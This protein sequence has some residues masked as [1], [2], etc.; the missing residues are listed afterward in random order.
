MC[1]S[2][3]IFRN[4]DNHHVLLL[5]SNHRYSVSTNLQY[6]LRFLVQTVQMRTYWY[7]VQIMFSAPTSDVSTAL[8]IRL[9][10]ICA[11]QPTLIKDLFNNNVFNLAKTLL[12]ASL[13]QIPPNLVLQ[14]STMNKMHF[15]SNFLFSRVSFTYKEVFLRSHQTCLLIQLISTASH[16]SSDQN[17]K[18]LLDTF[19]L[20]HDCF[21]VQ[22]LH[23]R[24]C[25]FLQL[26]VMQL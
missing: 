15:S 2:F 1:I 9:N 20:T 6:S 5:E 18:L 23:S 16:C 22:R 4:R 14:L 19:S 25:Y 10:K 3:P 12:L 24:Q 8:R 13:C 26:T 11:W 17:I 7:T 21:H